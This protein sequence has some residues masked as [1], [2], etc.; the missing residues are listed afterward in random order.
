MNLRTDQRLFM[1]NY[2]HVL[3]VLRRH[4]YNRTQAARELGISYRGLFFII[5]EMRACGFRVPINKKYPVKKVRRKREKIKKMPNV[6]GIDVSR[7]QD[8]PSTSKDDVD[9]FKV[10][11]DSLKPKFVYLRGTI[12]ADSLDVQ[13]ENFYPKAKAAGLL[14]G[15]YHLIWPGDGYKNEIRDIVAQC[16]A[17]DFDLPVALDVEQ[18]HNM[19]PDELLAYLMNLCDGLMTEGI[20]PIIYTANWFWKPNVAR[21]KYWKDFDLWVASYTAAPI[22][23]PDF[24]RWTIWQKSSTYKIQGVTAN[25]ID[26]ND[27]NGDEIAFSSWLNS[28]KKKGHP[29]ADNSVGDLLG[30]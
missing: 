3:K 18:R 6:T 4:K 25:T 26:V 21:S 23:P 20:K 16:K 27:F 11:G 29:Y 7:W 30:G 9:W 2:R 14:V 12:G 1:A 13:Y 10:V 15:M 8:S 24:D 17:K 22:M 5:A 19:T 28:Y